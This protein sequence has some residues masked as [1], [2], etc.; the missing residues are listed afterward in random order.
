MPA[1]LGVNKSQ[2]WPLKKLPVQGE[3]LMIT[4]PWRRILPTD[5]TDTALATGQS[6]LMGGG[7]P[8]SL[9]AVPSHPKVLGP[10]AAPVGGERLMSGQ[11]PGVSFITSLWGKGSQPLCKSVSA[12]GL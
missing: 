3:G 5:M 12:A 10:G 6:S 4:V 7:S 11:V 8:D 2:S 9:L 1:L